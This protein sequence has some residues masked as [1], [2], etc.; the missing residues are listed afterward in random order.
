MKPK[1]EVRL[2]K[3]YM[4]KSKHENQE[5]DEYTIS[6][7]LWETCGLEVDESGREVFTLRCI[8]PMHESRVV[9][10]KIRMH[11]VAIAVLC[12]EVSFVRRDITP[13]EYR[14]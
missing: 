13:E 9:G 5:P 3:Q 7:G 12:D 2:V 1:T 8:M 4:I 11:S 14:R 10:E 6:H